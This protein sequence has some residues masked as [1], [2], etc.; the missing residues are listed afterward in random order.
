MHTIDRDQ[1]DFC[2]HSGRGSPPHLNLVKRTD[3][4]PDPPTFICTD[5]LPGLEVIGI[6][7]VWNKHTLHNADSCYYR[8]GGHQKPHR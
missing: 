7:V 8:R 5:I 1:L 4:P 6:A 2:Y 3:S